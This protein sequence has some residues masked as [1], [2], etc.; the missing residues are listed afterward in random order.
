MSVDSRR[1]ARR[2]GCPLRGLGQLQE[3]GTTGMFQ[4]LVRNAGRH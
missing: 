2:S 1:Q 4:R 3:E